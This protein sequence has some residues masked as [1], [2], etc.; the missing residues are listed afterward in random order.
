[1]TLEGLEWNTFE[2]LVIKWNAAFKDLLEDEK[3]T[4]F[5]GVSCRK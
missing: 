4:D 3:T 5:I 2:K 1:V